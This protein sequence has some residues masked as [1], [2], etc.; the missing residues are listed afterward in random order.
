MTDPIDFDP[1]LVGLWPS[2]HAGPAPYGTGADPET[3]AA[4]RTLWLETKAAAEPSPAEALQALLNDMT[5]ELKQQFSLF[6]TIRADAQQ[7]LA[8]GDEGEQKTAKSD[9]KAAVDA[10]SLITRTLEKID[11]LQR[12]LARDLEAAAEQEFSEAVYEDMLAS[13][14]R[15]I[16]ER[17][18]E[19]MRAWLAGRADAEAGAT[20]PPGA[21]GEG[22]VETE[23]PPS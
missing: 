19:R 14:D 20:G 2:G 6:Q 10:L 5:T 16:N 18:E 4:V 22:G 9:V 13:I 11:S 12:S 7:K 21:A 8:S 15:K 17:A 23:E 3:D 1:A